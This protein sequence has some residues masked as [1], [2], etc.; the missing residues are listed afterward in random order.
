MAKVMWLPPPGPDDPIFSEPVRI[1]S[2]IVSK[3]APESPPT[4]TE[5]TI[6]VDDLDD[7]ETARVG[8]PGG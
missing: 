3:G 2:V 7:E 5:E 1:T 4:S 6:P 8:Q